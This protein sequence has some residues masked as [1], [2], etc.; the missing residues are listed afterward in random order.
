MLTLGKLDSAHT[1]LG[2]PHH[3]QVRLGRHYLREPPPDHRM[4]I[5]DQD[6]NGC[7]SAHLVN[8]PHLARRTPGPQSRWRPI[9]SAPLAPK[10]SP[11]EFVSVGGSLQARREPMATE[12]SGMLVC[13]RGFIMSTFTDTV[14]AVCHGPACRL[15]SSDPWPDRCVLGQ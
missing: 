9:A 14:T 11:P 13:T 4:I 5:R 2:G 7:R 10:A 6:P 12:P 8:V 3:L 1:V 15:A